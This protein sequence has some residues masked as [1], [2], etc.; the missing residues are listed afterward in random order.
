MHAAAPHH[1]RSDSPPL[2]DRS[3]Y[4]AASLALAIASLPATLILGLGAVV[5]TA[6]IICGVLGRRSAKRHLAT[7]GIIVGA[8]AAAASLAGVTLWFMLCRASQQ[9]LIVLVCS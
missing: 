2:P 4:A 1:N 8:I 3:G 5:G 9:I 7:F 6:A